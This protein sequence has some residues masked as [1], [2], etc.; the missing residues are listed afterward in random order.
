M[1]RPIGPRKCNCF[2]NQKSATFPG[3]FV[4]ARSSVPFARP[5]RKLRRTRGTWLMALGEL[6]CAD[7]CRFMVARICVGGWRKASRLGAVASGAWHVGGVRR[8]PFARRTDCPA[9]KERATIA[10]ASSFSLA[11][12]THILTA[13]CDRRNCRNRNHPPP[14]AGWIARK[15]LGSCGRSS[16]LLF[17]RSLAAQAP[18]VA[19]TIAFKGIPGWVLVRCRMRISLDRKT[20]RR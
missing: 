7:D 5:R 9:P 4:G 2:Y 1:L 16:G 10:R 19:A 8:R 17:G 3:K 6:R 12:P 20:Q 18:Y 14:D 15:Q 13:V 11:A